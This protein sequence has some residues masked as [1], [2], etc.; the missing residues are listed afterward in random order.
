LRLAGG[1]NFIIFL[2]GH[3]HLDVDRIAPQSNYCSFPQKANYLQSLFY[4]LWSF[5]G[6]TAVSGECVLSACEKKGALGLG[7]YSAFLLRPVC[8]FTGITRSGRLL[9]VERAAARRRLQ[10]AGDV[11]C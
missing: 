1:A 2:L 5:D 10:A 11:V 7:F 4:E 8:I 3:G 6:D 9:A